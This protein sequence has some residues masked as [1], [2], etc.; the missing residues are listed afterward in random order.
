MGLR[1]KNTEVDD[2]LMATLPNLA[3]SAEQKVLVENNLGLVGHIAHAF[4]GYQ[5]EHEELFQWGCFGLMH[6]AMKYDADKGEFKSYAG[7]WIRCYIKSAVRFMWSQVV[8]KKTTAKGGFWSE[9]GKFRGRRDAYLSETVYRDSENVTLL[10]T[11]SAS[12]DGSVNE[13]EKS[14]QIDR[15]SKVIEKAEQ[16]PTSPLL[17]R[18][19]EVI[20]MVYWDDQNFVEIG[21]KQH[22]HKNR[23]GFVHDRAMAKLQRAA[24]HIQ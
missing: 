5:M 3:L 14:E 23:I 19:K 12:S 6:A 21:K 20:K 18:E 10:D 9:E 8:M 13:F 15:L 16:H 7:T 1:H 24:A 2:H 11:L 4:A 22:A 17:P